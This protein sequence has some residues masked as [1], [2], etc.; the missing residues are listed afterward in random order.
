M[1]LWLPLLLLSPPM[2]NTTEL[3]VAALIIQLLP[4][5]HNDSH[6]RQLTMNPQ[7]SANAAS[8]ATVFRECYVF[9]R[10]GLNHSDTTSVW[11]QTD[12]TFRISRALIQ[13][14]WL[15]SPS[16]KRH[17]HSMAWMQAR[18]PT[19]R[20]DIMLMKAL[21]EWKKAFNWWPAEWVING[22]PILQSFYGCFSLCRWWSLDYL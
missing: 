11:Y 4:T 17:D 2:I 3:G 21:N 1:R 15:S 22:T 8:T 7:Q 19:T 14:W 16:P 6:I 20:Q 13:L 10:C 9:T 18:K 5:L 12:K